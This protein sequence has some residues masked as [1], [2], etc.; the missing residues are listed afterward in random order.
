MALLKLLNKHTTNKQEIVVTTAN[1]FS[2][3]LDDCALFVTNL[4]IK[5]KSIDPFAHVYVQ[6]SSFYASSTLTI[7]RTPKKIDH[8]FMKSIFLATLP[9]LRRTPKRKYISS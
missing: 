4:E 5:A 1:I 7:A 9:K 2:S 8:P 6:F 3:K